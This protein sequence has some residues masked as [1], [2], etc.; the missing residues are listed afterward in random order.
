M[1]FFAAHSGPFYRLTVDRR[2]G[3]G[4]EGDRVSKEKEETLRGLM[5]TSMAVAVVKVAGMQKKDLG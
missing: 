4:G 5:S 3:K 1:K 2:K